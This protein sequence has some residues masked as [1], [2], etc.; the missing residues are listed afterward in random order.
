MLIPVIA[1]SAVVFIQ[2]VYFI[3]FLVAFSK[4]RQV[5]PSGNFPVS[6]IVCAH[7]EEENLRELV[8]LLLN[9]N[10]P[11]FEVIIVNDRSNDDT[12]D[13]LLEETRNHPKVKMVNVKATPEHVNSKKY[14]ITLGI[15]AATHEWI[16]L[17]DA[18]CRPQNENWINAV[19][20]NFED[21]KQFV[22]GFS[23]YIAKP[24]FLNMFIRFESIITA[25]QYLSFAWM[26]NP[27][28]GV[29]RNLAYRKSLFLEKKGFNNM[30][31]V[32]GGDDDLFVNEH[33]NGKNTAVAVSAD[34]IVHSV[35]KTTWRSFFRQKIRHLKV[36]K[37]YKFGHKFLLGI[38]KFT[39]LLTWAVGLPLMFLYEY[40]Y[41]IIIAF[42]IRWSIM[43][44]STKALLKKTGLLFSLWMIP[45]LDFVYPIYY[46]SAGL[47]ALF[48]KRVQ[49]KN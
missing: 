44:W 30:L 1:L 12:Y 10:Y 28:M 41:F 42:V 17:T 38:F 13:F 5:K 2:L 39:W 47:A 32:M 33:A 22:L 8:P 16:L 31:H 18:D 24:G 3:I 40:Y 6:I 37:R 45:I 14:A 23:P 20:T 11:E 29:G 27:Y 46:I 19:S 49:W 21:N 15:R 36:G 7:D 4:K 43:A 35:A 34:A 48:T 9:Q 26:K 25:L